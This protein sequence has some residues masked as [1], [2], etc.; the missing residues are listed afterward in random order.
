MHKAENQLQAAQLALGRRYEELYGN[1]NDPDLAQYIAD[2]ANARAQI[3]AAHAELTS[4]DQA[5]VCQ[6]CHQF[7]TENQK[8]CPHCGT[9]LFHRDPIVDTDYQE[10]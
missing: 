10:L 6:K 8:F 3:A 4:L 2:I 1:R 5:F 9:E 7:V